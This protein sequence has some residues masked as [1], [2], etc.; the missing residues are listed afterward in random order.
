[1]SCMTLQ[2]VLS[3]WGYSNLGISICVVPLLVDCAYKC[4][5]LSPYSTKYMQHPT[6][7]WRWPQLT[8]SA[9]ILDPK[10]KPMR[11]CCYRNVGS[12]LSPNFWLFRA[13]FIIHLVSGFCF[14]PCHQIRPLAKAKPRLTCMQSIQA[15]HY[16]CLPR[17]NS[18]DFCHLLRRVRQLMNARFK[19]DTDNM[20][21]CDMSNISM[22]N[23]LG[24]SDRSHR[25]VARVKDV[26]HRGLPWFEYMFYTEYL[27]PLSAAHNV[28]AWR[29]SCGQHLRY[30]RYR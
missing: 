23:L 11:S 13:F 16:E 29:C 30:V 28:L 27:P 1:M 10:Q 3:V 9:P 14:R 18:Y 5:C 22:Q 21:I 26:M 8:L 6:T 15:A 2:I 12:P 17:N 4:F 24:W 7:S 20:Y 19:R 25:A